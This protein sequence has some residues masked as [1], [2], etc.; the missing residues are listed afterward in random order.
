MTSLSP[1]P[2]FSKDGVIDALLG[3]EK[4]VEVV[5]VSHGACLH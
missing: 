1:G 3:V 2:Q 5:G 4:A